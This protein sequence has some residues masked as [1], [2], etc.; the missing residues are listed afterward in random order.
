VRSIQASTL[1]F[2]ILLI[3]ACGITP[4]KRGGTNN[5]GVLS[6]AQFK[7]L[8]V[9]K[10]AK[11]LIHEF[12]PP[13][14]QMKNE[15]RVVAIAYRAEN[16]KGEEEELRIALDDKARVAKWTLAPRKKDR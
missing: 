1:L 4:M 10:P 13:A 14:H 12:G 6:Y 3:G 15:G 7:T 2:G 11:E 8:E 5:P 9:G 16:G